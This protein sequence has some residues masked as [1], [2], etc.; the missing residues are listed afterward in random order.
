[1]SLTPRRTSI[2]KGATIA[3][4]TSAWPARAFRNPHAL[5]TATTLVTSSYA[6]SYGAAGLNSCVRLLPDRFTSDGLVTGLLGQALHV[7]EVSG[8][9]DLVH[10]P[11]TAQGQRPGH[12]LAH[13]GA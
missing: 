3:V 10:G 11:V 7:G 4:S 8:I 12:D 5:S 13:A 9:E 1:M 2:R 6:E